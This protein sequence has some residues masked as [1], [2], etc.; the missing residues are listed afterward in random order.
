MKEIGP[1]APICFS[2][3]R[4]FGSPKYRIYWTTNRGGVGVLHLVGSERGDNAFSSM[5][6]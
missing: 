2:R 5:P 3:E 4:L 6:S 1:P